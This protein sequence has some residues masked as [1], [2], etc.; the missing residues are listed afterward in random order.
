MCSHFFHA[1]LMR[2]RQEALLDAVACR[3]HPAEHAAVG[4]AHRESAGLVWLPVMRF[5][6]LRRLLGVVG[7]AFL[8]SRRRQ[9]PR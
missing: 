6:R 4:R 5:A 8:G 2:T 9:L 3:R 1:E 7:P